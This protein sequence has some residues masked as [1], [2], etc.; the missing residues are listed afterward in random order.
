V[1]L[2]KDYDQRD[3]RGFGQRVMVSMLAGLIPLGLVILVGYFWLHLSLTVFLS[4]YAV[5][6]LLVVVTIILAFRSTTCPSCGQTIR[7]PWSSVEFR[8]GGMLRYT[9]D[10][11]RIIWLTHLY[12]GSDT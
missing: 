1:D 11:C 9:C 8:R 3:D 5:T 6:L 4:I 2:P 12:P 10:N 7:V